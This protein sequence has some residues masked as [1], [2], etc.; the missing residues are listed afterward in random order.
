[1]LNTLLA[2]W[3]PMRG[4]VHRV[5]GMTILFLATF[6]AGL[7]L[8]VRVMMYGVERPREDNPA[9]ERSFRLSPA[10]IVVFLIAFGSTGYVLTRRNAGTVAMVLGISAGLGIVLSLIAAHFVKKWWV[11]TPEHDVDDVRYILQGHIARVTKPIRAD[12]DGEVAYEL[13]SERHVLR[14]RS[15]D[16]AAIAAGTEVVIERIEDD[17]AYVE[18]WMEVE[19]RL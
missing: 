13:G 5:L 11:I 14:A 9:G 1:M 8:A 4:D 18:A 7:L 12:V 15:F 10:I 3:P 19:K 17:V 6:V 16:E 2:S